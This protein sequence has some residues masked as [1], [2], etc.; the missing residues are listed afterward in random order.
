[1]RFARVLAD[2]HHAGITSSWSRLLSNKAVLRH[3]T[4]VAL[5]F[6]VKQQGWRFLPRFYLPPLLANTF[7]GAVLFQSYEFTQAYLAKRRKSVS[8]E[9]FFRYIPAWM[10]HVLAG[11]AAGALYASV[12]A[13]LDAVQS[14]IATRELLAL[15][16]HREHQGSVSVIKFARRTLHQLG[17]RG[18]YHGFGL[19]MM[20]DAIGH[21]MFF[22]VYEG[23]KERYNVNAS[24]LNSGMVIVVS[25]G[26]AAAAYQVIESPFEKMQQYMGMHHSNTHIHPR[27]LNYREALRM[28]SHEP[29]WLRGMWHGLTARLVRTVPATSL[30]LL[31]YETMKQHV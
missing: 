9:S 11:G 8:D 30:G 21:A 7:I 12:S 10:D 18:V 24:G 27:R 22:G 16:K 2:E 4:P 6:A 13:P 23:V 31:V 1:M 19:V 3:T 14:R 25:G 5:S 26:I 15:S 17:F 29:A 28:L 20:K